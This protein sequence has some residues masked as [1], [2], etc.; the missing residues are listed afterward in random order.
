MNRLKRLREAGVSI[1][2][3]D[4]S[5]RWTD[6]ATLCRNRASPSPSGGARR[7][8]LSRVTRLKRLVVA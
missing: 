1:G 2:P 7:H 5:Q 6:A 3:T 8:H 4:P